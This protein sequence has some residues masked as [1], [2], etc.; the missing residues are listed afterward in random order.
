MNQVN[1]TTYPWAIIGAGPAG[2][3]SVGLLLESGVAPKDIL[4]IDPHFT[5]GDFGQFWG[6]V[7]SNTS[8]ELFLR[9]LND[10]K[11]FSFNKRPSPFS[12][13]SKSPDD[14]CQLKE[15]TEALL[16]ITHNLRQRICTAQG[17]VSDLHVE[18]G[19]WHINMGQT[20]YQADKVI[21]ATGSDPKSLSHKNTQ[22]ITL[23]TA[24]NPDQLNRTINKNDCIAVFGSSH[25]SMIIMKNL[26]DAGAKNIINFYQTPHRYAIK[27]DGWTLYDNTGLKAATAD[28]VRKN[29]SQQL[30][31]RIKRYLSNQDNIEQHMP[32]CN[33]AVYPIGFKP[34]TPHISGIDCQQYDPNT[35]IIAPGLF[36]S[37]IAFPR[38]KTDPL[39]NKE[40]SV[41]LYKFMNDIREVLPL[42]SQYGL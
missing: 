18:A 25:S 36:G 41:G 11:G 35:G 21:L 38:H 15:V 20:S 12:I 9:F 40:P 7:Y 27:M 19:T 14:F 4:L 23:Y 34:R 10:I 28:W 2:L 42:W 13:E 39:G 22:E 33:K 17:Y 32:T 37:G 30:D 3:T 24:L 29:I 31:C 16:W 1:Q 8:I 6:E 26:L 5:V